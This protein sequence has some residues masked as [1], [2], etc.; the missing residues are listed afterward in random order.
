MLY[1]KDDIVYCKKNFD[2]LECKLFEEGKSYVIENSWP[3]FYNLS[4]V[5]FYK[6]RST[7]F[8]DGIKL[9]IDNCFHDYFCTLNELRKIKLKKLKRLK[10]P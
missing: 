5:S 8:I 2:F 10:K 7:I 9:K 6:I 4:G 3:G 1:K